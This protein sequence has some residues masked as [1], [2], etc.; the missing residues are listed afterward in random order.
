MMPDNKI[1]NV[2]VKKGCISYNSYLI[3]GEKTALIDTVPKEFGTEFI[4][5]VK[6]ALGGTSLNYIILNHTEPDRSG[7][8]CD[9]LKIFP[10][11]VVISTVAGLKNITEQLNKAF[12][13][14]LA[15]SNATLS[16]DNDT[17]LKF[18]ITHNINW[19][20]SMMT[21][22]VEEKALFSCDA[23]SQGKDGLRAYYN[24]NLSFLPDYVY[25]AMLTITELDIDVIYPATGVIHTKPADVINEYLSWCTPPKKTNTKFLI[26]YESFSGN[27]KA[28]A[29][30]AYDCLMDKGADVLIFDAANAKK[31]DILNAIYE[32]DGIIFGTPT[33][34][35]N[36]SD[37]ISHILISLN[38][39]R[40]ANKKFAAFGSFG[41]SGEAPNLLY[42]ILRARHF[43]TF[44]SA[45]RFMFT[46]TDEDISNFKEYIIKFYK[47]VC[48]MTK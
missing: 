39:F 13:Q 31:D 41:W 30:I 36:I 33:I 1:L 43:D 19:P 47:C 15:K 9:L 23:F 24:K 48:D 11:T 16:L 42:S 2:G 28:L 21:L 29:E 22:L 8:L 10:D 34:Y 32:S 7:A 45:F 40:M 20:D 12:C 14:Q 18:I 4:K 3:K 6:D 37:K 26:V 46:P 5:N 17:T 25:Q 44:S 35:R 27:T 38:H